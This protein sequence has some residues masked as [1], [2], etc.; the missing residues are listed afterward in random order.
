LFQELE[1]KKKPILARLAKERQRGGQGGILLMDNSTK[2]NVRDE[3][4][5]NS[6]VSNN[7]VQRVEKVLSAQ[8]QEII[9]QVRRGDISI[10]KAYTTI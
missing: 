8:D 2:A 6:G 5:D 1:L 7:T 4:A 9:D 3:I 10:N